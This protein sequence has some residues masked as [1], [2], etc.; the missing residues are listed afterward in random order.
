MKPKDVGRC[1]KRAAETRHK[2]DLFRPKPH[3]TTAGCP[4]RN[5]SLICLS[6]MGMAADVI[7]LLT[8]GFCSPPLRLEGAKWFARR[9]WL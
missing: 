7:T 9:D 1:P 4:K 2:E 8:L 3:W 5:V 6:L